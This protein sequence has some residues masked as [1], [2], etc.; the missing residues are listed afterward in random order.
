MT[1]ILINNDGCIETEAA[2]GTITRH[3]RE[4][5]KG[6]KTS[7]NPIASIFAWTKALQYRGKY[8]NNQ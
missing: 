6:N 5:L 3:Y 7:T 1:S 4:H 8:D 2:H